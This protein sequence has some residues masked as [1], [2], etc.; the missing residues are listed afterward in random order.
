MQA[1]KNGY[2]Y[3]IDR[4]NGNFISASEMAPVS[5]AK[6]IDPKTGKVDI[7]PDALYSSEKGV[8]V[9]PVQMHT[10][11][12]MAFNPQTGLVYVPI[13]SDGSFS[14]TASAAPYAATPGRQNFGLAQGGRGGGGAA[15]P[16]VAV[17]PVHGP[18]RKRADGSTVT[19]GIL[20]AWD[21]ATQTEKWFAEGGGNTNGG[22]LSLSTNLV[23]QALTN[24]R[25]KVFTADTG[26]LVHEFSLPLN[27][28]TGAPITYMLD[29]KQYIA[30]AAGTTGAAAGGRGGGPGGPGGGA[31]GGAPGGRGAAGAP[32]AAAPGGVPAIPGGAPA[33]GQGRGGRGG[34]G[35]GA[36]PQQEATAAAA[37]AA[38]APQGGRGAAPG[39]APGGPGGGRGG[40]P[41]APPPPQAPLLPGATPPAE[42]TN[43]KLFVFRLP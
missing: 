20:T 24:G 30:I 39:G 33:G 40:A 42:N 7:H 15:A 36:P 14:F 37:A 13:A 26:K 8:T 27:G 5:W 22:M 28:G 2:F 38:N 34:P 32:G 3:V 12:P 9:H 1:N 17:P 19:G 25:I 35:A 10:T 29:G 43:P 31:P 4:T 41:A 11:S 16:P 6:G 23:I 18:V 21:P